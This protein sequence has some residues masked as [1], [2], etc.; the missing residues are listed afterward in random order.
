MSKF[1]G[2][3]VGGLEIAAGAALLATGVGA[4]FAPYLISAGVGT[5][6][7]GLGTLLSKGPVTGSVTSAKNPIAPWLIPYGENCVGG[8]PVYINSWGDSDKYLD[9]VIVV[10]ACSI[11]DIWGLRFDG[12]RI[13]IDTTAVPPGVPGSDFPAINGG[14]SFTPVQQTINIAAN[15]ATRLNNVVTISLPQN[16]P[17]L[18]VGDYVYVSGVQSLFT[19][20]LVDLNGKWQVSNIVSQVFGTGSPPGPGSIIFQYVSGGVNFGSDESNGGQVKTAWPDY[21]RKIYME[22]LLGKQTLGETFIGLIS[23]TPD[24]GDVDNLLQPPTPNWSSTCSLQGKAAVFLRLHYNDVYFSNGLPQISVLEHGKDDIYDPRLSPPG[25]AYTNNAALVVADYLAQGAV[26][27]GQSP[28]QVGVPQWG[29]GALY[30]TE[31]PIDKLIQAANICDEEVQLNVTFGNNAAETDYSYFTEKRYTAN[32]HFT[33]DRKRG[34]ILQNLLTSMAGR[35]TYSNG[36]YIIWPAAWQGGGTNNSPFIQPYGSLFGC[37]TSGV[38]PETTVISSMWIGNGPATFT[39]PPG[40][41]Y[42]QLGV[43]SGLI[44]AGSW[45]I[46]VTVNGVTTSAEVLFSTLCWNFAGLP[47]VVNGGLITVNGPMPIQHT[48]GYT[49][50][51]YVACNPGDTVTIT[52]V[53]G[54]IQAALLNPFLDANGNAATMVGGSGSFFPSHYTITYYPGPQI[55]APAPLPTLAGPIKWVPKRSFRDLFNGVKGT[56]ICPTNDWQPGDFP[57]FCQDGLHGYTWST[58]EFEN[59]QNLQQD[60]G[61][62]LWKD[63]QLPFTTSFAAAQR[64]AKIELLRCRYQGTG[65]IKFN[66]WGYQLTAL[67]I[68]LF[69]F[70]YFG[71]TNKILEVSK[72]RFI[73]EKTPNDPNGAIALSTEVDVQETSPSI[74]DWLPFSDQLGPQGYK[75]GIMPETSPNPDPVFMTLTEK[76]GPAYA[77]VGTDGISRAAILLEWPPPTDGYMTDG[78]HVEMQYQIC[79]PMLDEIYNGIGADPLYSPPKPGTTWIELPHT[80]P[81]AAS[82]K[83]DIELDNNFWYRFQVRFVNAAGVPSNWVDVFNPVLSMLPEHAVIAIQPF[84]SPTLVTPPNSTAFNGAA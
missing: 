18:T 22:T 30:G 84:A 71:W 26:I 77:V 59:D 70:P 60:G 3:I 56:Y 55:E 27:P 41:N 16:I 73:L 51:V 44:G 7:S 83:T 34:E 82:Y 15:G 53:G 66:M 8:T 75:Q 78:G 20:D 37:F 69:S 36:Q 32:G 61:A 64:I 39:A 45:G 50:P 29:F 58:A 23:G 46:E 12:Q 1:V 79:D 76:T 47:D 38:I 81:F 9:M 2:V 11:K 17:L 14:T 5:L 57:P 43:N 19:H 4:A 10:A 24:D 28:P 68:L 63:I 33:L 48:F 21:G 6:I 62:R 54:T 74:Y 42:L 67:D 65:T 25:N 13:Q 35:L 31:I 80:T 52:Y 49:Q 40:T 72:H